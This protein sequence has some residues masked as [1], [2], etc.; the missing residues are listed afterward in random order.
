MIGCGDLQTQPDGF[1]EFELQMYGVLCL[2]PTLVVPG[3]RDNLILGSNF[4]KHIIHV[5]KGD[6][7]YWDIVFGHGHQPDPDIKQ[8]LSMFTSVVSWEG[9]NVP[10]KIRTV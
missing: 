8:F 6:G 9:C 5:M 4:I 10:D 3:Q 1:Y 7:D 2:L